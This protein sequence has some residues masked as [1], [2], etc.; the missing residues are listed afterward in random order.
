[1]SF[2]DDDASSASARR[3]RGPHT[4][5]VPTANLVPRKRSSPLHRRKRRPVSDIPGVQ[6]LSPRMRHVLGQYLM[7]DSLGLAEGDL[8]EAFQQLSGNDAAQEW[9]ESEWEARCNESILDPV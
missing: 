2:W 9:S 4:A 6:H 5:K 1:M 8:V 3:R 7:V